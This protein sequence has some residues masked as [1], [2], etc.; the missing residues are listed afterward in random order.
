MLPSALFSKN[1]NREKVSLDE[2]CV[3]TV[4]TLLCRHRERALYKND[5]YQFPMYADTCK[6]GDYTRGECIEKCKLL[7]YALQL[8][9]DQKKKERKVGDAR[10]DRKEGV[11]KG[12]N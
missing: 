1:Y 5:K 10:E 9:R 2:N 3:L 11:G 12:G 7:Q 4:F 6:G 8:I